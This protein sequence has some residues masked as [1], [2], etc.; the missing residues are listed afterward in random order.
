MF[1]LVFTQLKNAASYKLVD[2]QWALRRLTELIG[3]S[4]V[5]I[6]R[7]ACCKNRHCQKNASQS[8]SGTAAERGK[9]PTNKTPPPEQISSRKNLSAD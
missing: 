2:K 6:A 1:D 8:P 5:R 3:M 4:W 7:C 9:W